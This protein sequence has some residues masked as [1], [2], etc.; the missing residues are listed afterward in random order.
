[1]LLASLLTSL[2]TGWTLSLPVLGACLKARGDN[3]EAAVHLGSSSGSLAR[4]CERLTTLWHKLQQLVKAGLTK[5]AAA[6]LLK[7]YAGPASQ[8]P[9]QL[10]SSTDAEVTNYDQQLTRCWEDLAERQF[11]ESAKQQLGLPPK[12][13]GCGVHYASTRR[14]AAFWAT[15][16]AA[17]DDV[18]KELGFSTVDDLLD[19]VPNL[20]AQ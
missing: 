18:K 16:T 4:V 9:L 20:K 3:L 8:Y 19:A 17:V 11:D 1:M 7:S 15:W 10:E 2:L 13:G 6:A 5:Q 14:H 12:L